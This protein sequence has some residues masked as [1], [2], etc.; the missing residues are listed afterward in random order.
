[1][2]SLS[3]A[4]LVAAAALVSILELDVAQAGQFMVS[5]P[6]VVGALLG[7]I[8]DR[9][10]PGMFLGLCFELLSLDD[11]PV[12]DNL[13]V[14]ATVAAAAALLLSWGPQKVVLELALPAG[15]GAG[16]VHQ[17][18]ESALRQRRSGLCGR[19]EGS[20][21]RG[22][23][24]AFAVMVLRSLA[25]QAAATWA[26]LLAFL[27]VGGPVLDFLWPYAPSALAEGLSFGLVFAPWLG[28][29][30]LLHGLRSFR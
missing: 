13:P 23:P 3:W 9:A 16:W 17:R 2:E 19:M 26:V 30:V 6:V 28:L 4:A 25:E 11:L 14:N 8:F 29:A 20:L 10:L 15:L 5:R 7:I 12:G 18:V 24:P 22:E 27:L 21:L 1:M